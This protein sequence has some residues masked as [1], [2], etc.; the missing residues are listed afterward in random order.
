MKRIAPGRRVQLTIVQQGAEYLVN[1]TLGAQRFQFFH[2]AE[3]LRAIAQHIL[4]A[5]EPRQGGSG[6]RRDGQ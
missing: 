5:I 6:G 4:A 3:Q 2:T 1:V